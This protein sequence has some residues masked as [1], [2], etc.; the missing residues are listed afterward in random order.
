[1]DQ[2]PFLNAIPTNDPEQFINVP[3]AGLRVPDD[4][5]QFFVQRDGQMVPAY[6]GKDGCRQSASAKREAV[7][8][9][10]Q[11]D[12]SADSSFRRSDVPPRDLPRP[13][14]V[15]ISVATRPP[16]PSA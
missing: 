12:R 3:S 16:S 5:Q 7:S 4:F 11:S 6:S 10:R 2:E 15:G 13:G 1:M 8:A 9:E 14:R